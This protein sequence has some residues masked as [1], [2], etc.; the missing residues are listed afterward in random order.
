MTSLQLREQTVVEGDC[1]VW[2]G[3]LNKD[4]YGYVCRNGSTSLAH[5]ISYSIHLGSPGRLLVMHTCDRRSCVNP[6]HLV[7][8]THADN[9]ADMVKK[10]RQCCGSRHHNAILTEDEVVLIKDMLRDGLSQGSVA[11][12]FGVSVVSVGKIARGITWKH[13][14]LEDR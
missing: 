8:G 3:S 6:D 14:V 5:R 13:V 7:L 11:N 9:S 12:A 4:G 2:Q 10:G 1:W